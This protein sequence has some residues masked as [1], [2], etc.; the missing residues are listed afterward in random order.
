[1]NGPKANSSRLY[2]LSYSPK[3]AYHRLSSNS[4]METKLGKC[5]EKETLQ[6]AKSRKVLTADGELLPEVVRE[7][8]EAS[9]LRNVCTKHQIYRFKAVCFGS[10]IEHL[11]LEKANATT[12]S[13]QLRNIM[14]Q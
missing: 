12:F 9:A 13:N 1:M 10:F 7:E 2:A 5:L 3:W 11:F 4:F 8:M 6:A 14:K